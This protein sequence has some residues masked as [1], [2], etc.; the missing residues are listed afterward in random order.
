[1]LE[2]LLSRVGDLNSVANARGK[3][4]KDMSIDV[5]E[6]AAQVF[7]EAGLRHECGAR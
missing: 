2:E 7:L 1:M 4:R 5:L 6:A 3:G